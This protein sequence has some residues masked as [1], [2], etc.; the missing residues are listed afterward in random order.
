MSET[1]GI[2]LIGLGTVGTGVVRI[3]KDKA[4][5]LE[6]RLGFPIRIVRVATLHPH[7]ERDLDLA[8]VV[9]DDDPHALIHDKNVSIVVELVG[10]IGIAKEI[11]LDAISSG[12]HLVTANKAL[13]AEHGFEIF[14]AAERFSV[15]VGFEAA[16]AG[17]VPILR[18]I[19]EGLSANKITFLAGIL[20]GTTNYML[21]EMYSFGSAF[22]L[23][24]SEAQRLG[25]AEADPSFDVDGNDAAQKLSL[26]ASMAFGAKILPTDIMTEG[27][28][29]LTPLD[30]ESARA[31]GYRIKLLGIARLHEG[32]QGES[33]EVRVH[34]T[35]IS[36]SSLLAKVDGSMNAVMV[37]GDA[38]GP[39][40]FYGA[41]AGSLPTAS[42]VVGD[43]M[44]ISREI[45]RGV[46][47]RV[48]S[49]SYPFSKLVRKNILPL[50]ET[51]APFYLVFDAVDRPGVLGKISGV[52]G[53]LGISIKSVIQH[54]AEKD[55][56]P[57]VVLTHVVS[58]NDIRN[59][60][61][62]I[63]KFP[64]VRGPAKMIRIDEGI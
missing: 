15:D 39:T 20:N 30:F 26:L 38:V 13:L 43:L 60:L 47:G 6:D 53:S 27:I 57:V 58:E 8:D 17:G 19:R 4:Q 37:N 64:E 54:G 34:P 61:N 49:L 63:S 2:G 16:V 32:A 25:F 46:T 5:M 22:E 62:E 31:F 23:V 55:S 44:E 42:A 21:S 24:L 56:V 3:L 52:L 28:R 14:S 45:K 35:M 41:G 18:S 11:C 59:A 40:M 48:P 33:V 1:I 50:S 7:R 10:G 12:K 29:G 51:K 9:V 36:E